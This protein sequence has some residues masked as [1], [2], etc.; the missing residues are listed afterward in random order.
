M[1]GVVAVYTPA[2]TISGWHRSRAS[3]MLPK[4]SIGRSSP[5]IASVSSATSSPPSSPSPRPG[6]RRRRFGDRRLR[7]LASDHNRPTRWLPTHRCCF[8]A[9][10]RRLLRHQV[11]QGR[12]RSHRGR[13]GR[14]RGHDGQPAARRRADGEQRR[15]RRA[16]GCPST[17]WVSHQAPHGTHGAIAPMLGLEPDQLRVVCPWVGGGFGSKAAVYVEY[18]VARKAAIALSRPVKW[19]ASRS[20][21]MVSLVQGRDV[22]THGP[23]GHHNDGKIVGLDAEVVARAA[24]PTRPSGRSCRCRR[25]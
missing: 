25:R 17:M 24:V 22:M 2:G 7:P 6:L 5:P 12:S 13:R 19:V 4:R 14:G 9:R 3:A 16:R 18:L 1:P 8:G 21:D 10:V 23:L 15:R 20:E 11:R